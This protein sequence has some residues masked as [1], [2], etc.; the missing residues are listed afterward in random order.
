MFL[1]GERCL[2][3]LF[4]IHVLG[5]VFVRVVDEPLVLVLI[6]G[7]VALELAGVV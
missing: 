1:L 5:S 6:S 7:A 4:F 3:L 2:S